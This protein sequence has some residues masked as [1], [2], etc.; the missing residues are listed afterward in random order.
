LCEASSDRFGNDPAVE[1]V[2]AMAELGKGNHARAEAMLQRL[3]ERHPRHLVAAYTAA[4][5]NI[6]LGRPGEAVKYLLELVREYPDY[7]AALGTLAS[8]LMPGPSYR[9]VLTYVNQALR[10]LT[11]LE[12]GVETGATLRL[13]RTAK[14][15][16]GVDPNLELLQ[17]D[18]I[19]S[20]ARLHACT[21]DEF[22]EKHT[23]ASEF[24]SMPLDLAFIDGMHS[25]E[26]VLRDFRSVESWANDHTIVILHDV[27][28]ILPLVAE[29]NRRTKFWVGDVWKAIWLLV[30]YRS[31]LEISIVPTPPSGLAIVR[32]LNSANWIDPIRW[33]GAIECYSELAYPHEEPGSWPDQLHIVDNT[34]AGWNEALGIAGDAS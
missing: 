14:R 7:P 6:E 26:F 27:L 16:V 18:E 32:G 24:D 3:R 11:Y 23:L 25:F 33:N 22:F 20:R 19:T 1:V 12:I 8:V 15:I 2:R 4:W 13:A 17:R 9:D 10:P 29:R 21:S 28:P 31:D 34:R 30:E 5:L